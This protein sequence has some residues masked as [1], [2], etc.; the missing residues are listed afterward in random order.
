[1]NK[2]LI[3]GVAGFIGSKVARRFL[4]D[5]FNVIGIDDLSMG[6]INN[7][8]DGIEF[9][10]G[11]LS[12]EKTIDSIPKNCKKILHLAGQSSGEISFENP[13]LDL[14][15]NTIST[16]NLIKYGIQNN[17]ER[18]VYAS[19]MSVY[20]NVEDYPI[21]E[22]VSCVPLSCYGVGKITAERY[23]QI[24]SEQLPYVSMRMFNVYGPGQ[25]MDNLKQGMVSIFL[26]Q[27]LRSKKIQVKGNLERFRDLIYI[28][29]VVEFWYRAALDDRAKNQTINIGTGVRTTVRNLLDEICQLIPGSIYYEKDVTPGDQAG[30]YADNRKLL[31]LFG[32][33]NFISLEHGLREFYEFSIKE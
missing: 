23:L 27:A 31:D 19:S 28:S 10:Q 29:D 2:L 33:H 22:S 7:V 32:K 30:I 15:K 20:G 1:M 17:A 26:E 3:T 9:I 24:Y 11:D 14:K 4:E 16:L 13:I 6:K 12:L 5:G 25:D 21:P 18:L 8:P